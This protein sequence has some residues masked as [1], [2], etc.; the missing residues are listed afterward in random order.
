MWPHEN[1]TIRIFNSFTPVEF[2]HPTGF[3]KVI[4]IDGFG[5]TSFL[6]EV[7]LKK[8]SPEEV[9]V[10]VGPLGVQITE[11]NTKREVTKFGFS[12]IFL[13][14]TMKAR[15]I[16]NITSLSGSFMEYKII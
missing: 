7:E 5:V 4:M 8:T 2:R 11:G 13:M 14:M 16:L 1:M 6:G 12:N 15:I 3:K 10:T 9:V